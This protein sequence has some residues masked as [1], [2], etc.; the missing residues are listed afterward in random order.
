VSDKVKKRS[1]LL[2][3]LGSP[4]S[5]TYWALFRYL[6]QFLMDGRV[7]DVPPVLR[8]LLVSGM[9]VPFRSGRSAEAYRSIWWDDGS[10]L[11][12]ISRRFQKLVQ[13]AVDVPVELAMRYGKPSVKSALKSL[14]DGP[15]GQPDEI[16]MIPLYPHYAM[17]SYESS[18]VEVKERLVELNGG[19]TLVVAPP[20][21]NHPGYIDALAQSARPFLGKEHD[22]LLF[23]YHGLPERHL[24]KSDPTG[25]HCLSSEDCC[26]V[27]S[28]A[29]RTC[30][31][32]QVFATTEFMAK[33]L[34]LSEGSYSVSF[35][36]RLGR[37]PWLQ[38]ATTDESDRLASTGIKRL[39]VICPAFVTDCLETLEEIGMA[40]KKQFLDAGGEEFEVIP[41]M[42]EHPAWVEVVAEWCRDEGG[43]PQPAAEGPRLA[44]NLEKP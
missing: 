43:P 2:V 4:D 20:Y 28:P 3:N 19:V 44:A 31:R 8:R 36:S 12:V 34:N 6:N 22:H 39:L 21:Y 14:L 7:I 18:V 10:P 29:H 13:E 11:I 35:Q 40:A 5:P 30:Y 1:V 26:R 17:S 27:A 16:L 32:H 9:I 24:R 38:P 15:A 37:D 23:S 33:K 25:E 42:N 41:C